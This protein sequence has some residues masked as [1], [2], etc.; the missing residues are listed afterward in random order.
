ML[1]V[2]SIRIRVDMVMLINTL[3]LLF[4]LLKIGGYFTPWLFAIFQITISYRFFLYT[5][6]I[7][8]FKLGC[9][10]SILW[11]CPLT[12]GLKQFKWTLLWQC[13]ILFKQIAR[14][15]GLVSLIYR[16]LKILVH[17][18]SIL[19]YWL[20]YKNYKQNLNIIKYTSG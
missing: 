3:S 13:S 2:C 14:F 17:F 18:Y 4:V 6:K 11:L 16:L 15:L 9:L 19:S 10:C 20:I 12:K 5:L 7:W 8:W 1:N